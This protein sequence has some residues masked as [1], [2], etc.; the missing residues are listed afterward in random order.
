MKKVCL[1]VLLILN[2][3]TLSAQ[4]KRITIGNKQNQ[5]LAYID[6]IKTY[7]KIVKKG[8]V[9]AEICK[10]IGDAYYYNANYKIAGE[11]YQRAFSL[12]KDLNPE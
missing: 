5:K 4:Q 6:A 7:E 8:F 3:L 11:W 1:F 12:A 2:F 10:K 9:N